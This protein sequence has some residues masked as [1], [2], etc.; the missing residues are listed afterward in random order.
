MK[1]EI[2]QWSHT[3][4]CFKN[5]ISKRKENNKNNQVMESEKYKCT[6]F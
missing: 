3:Y 5:R 6:A 1:K 2:T 4:Q